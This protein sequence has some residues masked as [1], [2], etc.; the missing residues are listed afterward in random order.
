[1]KDEARNTGQHSSLWRRDTQLRAKPV[2]F[3]SAGLIEPLKEE[4]LD[5]Q[6]GRSSGG[7]AVA[8]NAVKDTAQQPSSA[9]PIEEGDVTLDETL[10]QPLAST[11]FSSSPGA[12]AEADTAGTVAVDAPHPDG[13]GFMI[14]VTGDKALTAKLSNMQPQI[15]EPQSPAEESD[16]SSEVILFKGRANLTGNKA[17]VEPKRTEQTITLDTMRYEIRAVEA[18]MAVDPGSDQDTAMPSQARHRH[19]PK[20][21]KTTESEDEEQAIMADYIANMAED[22]DDG[23][24]SYSRQPIMNQD[25]GAD[26]GAIGNDSSE[27]S[28]SSDDSAA[29]DD[30]E[31][32]SIPDDGNAVDDENSEA[33]D[34]AGP[35]MDDETLARLLAKQEELGMGGDELLLAS[36]MAGGRGSAYYATNSRK[37]R[38]RGKAMATRTQGPFASASAVADAFDELDLMDWER[39]SLQNQRNRGRRGKPPVFDV[40][41]SELEQALQTAWQ[42]DR[43]SKKSR[44]IRREEQRAQGLL[45]KHADPD[46]P[47]LKYP[48]GMTLENM[49]TEMRTFLLGTE[50]R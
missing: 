7:E 3:V 4:P 40:S 46:D 13:I 20:C 39:P 35:T 44:K 28:T 30:E 6:D 2:S 26:D 37:S 34:A 47:R 23:D 36:D 1:M 5:N 14:D 43:E 25:L 27:V 45:G 31:E 11:E 18:E 24:E 49:I 42:K 29:S 22:S 8:V 50:P 48:T 15:P 33:D 19:K 32:G 41:D 9:L 38:R 17:Y 16:S 21:V 12:S 10:E